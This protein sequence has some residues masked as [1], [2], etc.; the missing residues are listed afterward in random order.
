M[1]I[2]HHFHHPAPDFKVIHYV[3]SIV[4]ISNNF[5]LVRSL[6]GNSNDI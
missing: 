6:E 4:D 2:M 1:F 5:T 3:V